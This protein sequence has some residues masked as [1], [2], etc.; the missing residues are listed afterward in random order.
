MMLMA[1]AWGLGPLIINLLSLV[2]IPRFSCPLTARE[3]IWT[4]N[5]G[6]R[7]LLGIF[8]IINLITCSMRWF[9]PES[10][11]Y[12]YKRGFKSQAK[13]YALL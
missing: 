2:I 5:L 4:E 7:Y 1:V 8:G 12:L 11:T 3:C 6:W 10:P 13:A 9:L